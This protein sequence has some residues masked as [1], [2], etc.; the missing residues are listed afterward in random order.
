MDNLRIEDLDGDGFDLRVTGP[1]LQMDEDSTIVELDVHSASS[2]IRWLNERFGLGGQ[3]AGYSQNLTITVPGVA[4][5]PTRE[6]SW[7]G[8]SDAPEW[9]RALAR[10][11]LGSP[12]E[13]KP[14]YYR[15]TVIE[16]REL[17]DVRRPVV[18]PQGE[19]ILNRVSDLLD[20]VDS[21]TERA[22]GNYDAWKRLA[23]ELGHDI[24]SEALA[25][26]MALRRI[27]ASQGVTIDGPASL[28]KAL[29]QLLSN[30]AAKLKQ[31]TQH[32]HEREQAMRAQHLRDTESSVAREREA[33]AA[34]QRDRDALTDKLETTRR[35][36]DEAQ[37]R[38]RG[39]RTTTG[40]VELRATTADRLLN[41]IDMAINDSN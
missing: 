22:V 26:V 7:R 29:N 5:G 38:I 17:L 19:G 13:S 40:D 25:D 23:A 14:D 20:D 2:M 4:G 3:V 24:P 32:W 41:M 1:V 34:V 8:D 12:V 9:L 15:D 10:I 16:L 30:H 36:L 18:S 6:I 35:A 37:I 39:N 28:V 33:R 11:A 21:A 27:L 31:Q